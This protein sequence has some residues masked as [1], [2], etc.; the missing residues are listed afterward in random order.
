[1]KRHKK[2]QGWRAIRLA[3]GKGPQTL[4]AE[5]YARVRAEQDA[6]RREYNLRAAA[7]IE[8]EAARRVA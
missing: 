1:M 5:E 3:A 4:T 8:A 2:E 7:A 6:R